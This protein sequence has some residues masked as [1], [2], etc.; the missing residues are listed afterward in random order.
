[1]KI[2]Y[3]GEFGQIYVQ[4]RDSDIQILQE[5][6]EIQ[7]NGSSLKIDDSYDIPEPLRDERNPT[8]IL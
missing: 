1:M 6:K 7:E 4:L 5:K 2:A 3:D 8:E